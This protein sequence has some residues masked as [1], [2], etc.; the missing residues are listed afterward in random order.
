MQNRYFVE[1]KTGKRYPS[2][3]YVYAYADS[4][5]QVRNIFKDYKLVC[6]DQ[7]D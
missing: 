7:T 1:W 5:E 2:T 3:F 4:S 6:V